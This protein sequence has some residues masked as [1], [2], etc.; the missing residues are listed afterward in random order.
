MLLN[1]SQRQ[2]LRGSFGLRDENVI[3]REV[4][5]QGGTWRKESIASPPDLWAL[6]LLPP[7]QVLPGWL[8]SLLQ[9]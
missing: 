9:V 1:F 4:A 8:R 2:G 3:R 5:D 6:P 7:K